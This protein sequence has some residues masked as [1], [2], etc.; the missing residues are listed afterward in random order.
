MSEFFLEL[1][2]EE[3]PANLQ[4][5]SRLLLLEGFQK[6]SWK[7]ILAGRPKVAERRSEVARKSATGQLQFFGLADRQW[8]DIK[9][10]VEFDGYCASKVYTF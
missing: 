3:I 6:L 2:S 1:F 7:V 5:S 10:Q 8:N 9:L 4:R